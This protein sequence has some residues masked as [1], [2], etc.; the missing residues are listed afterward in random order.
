MIPSAQRE[1]L[2]DEV[3]LSLI[4]SCGI[5]GREAAEISSEF[6]SAD[7]HELGNA[8]AISLLLSLIRRCADDMHPFSYLSVPITTGRAHIDQ[9]NDRERIIEYN[10]QRAHL[11]A[12]R[13][14]GV[15]QGMVIDPSRLMDI[16]AWRQ[17]DYHTFWVKVIE[18]FVERV[19]FLDGWQYSVGCTIEFATATAL[20]L[21]T[22]TENR[23]PI[24]ISSGKA[25]ISAAINEYEDRGRDA[26]SLRRSLSKV[27][28]AAAQDR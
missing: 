28:V 8:D 22:M 7:I 23:V 9:N 13:L 16:P 17:S 6:A 4:D 27:E 15:L 5:A 1:D 21:P 20:S 2:G 12:N 19:Y 3:I 11:A 10:K 26:T 18:Q 25:L 14:R 24:D